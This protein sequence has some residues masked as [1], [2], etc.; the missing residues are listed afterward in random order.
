MTY[1]LNEQIETREIG[2]MPLL[3]EYSANFDGVSYV[4][5]AWK[6]ID[7]FYEYSK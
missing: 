1:D 6:P 2:T 3:V 7:E 5:V 4:R